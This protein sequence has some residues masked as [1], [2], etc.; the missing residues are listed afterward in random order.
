MT[1][2][3]VFPF[4]F[5]YCSYRIG[6]MTTR[7]SIFKYLSFIRPY[8]TNLQRDAG[9]KLVALRAAMSNLDAL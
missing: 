3:A 9:N 5:L 8:S 2:S 7:R 4:C 1:G 6:I